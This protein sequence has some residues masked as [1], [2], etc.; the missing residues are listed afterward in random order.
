MCGF[1]AI[2]NLSG[3]NV[4][5]HVVQRMSRSIGHRGP[6][7]TGTYLKDSIGLG[8]R[9][10][11]ILDL[12]QA[13]NQ[14]MVSDCGRFVIVFNGEIFNYV[15]LR[16]ELRQLGHRFRSSGDTEVLLK[17]YQEWGSLCV[18]R[19]NGMWAFLIYDQV[20]GMLVGSRDRFG[21]KPLY[22]Y[23]TK[24]H[25]FYASEIKAI[26]DSGFYAGAT[27]WR[28]AADFL[29]RGKLDENENTMYEGVTQ[30]K[31]GSIFQIDM[32]GKSSQQTYWSVDRIPREIIQDP[33]STFAH[34]FADSIKLRMRS[35]VPVGV[36][37]S[38][39]L[40]STSIICE[41]AALRRRERQR[42]SNDDLL[43]FSFNT[44][45]FD[46]SRY[47]ADTIHQTN[48]ILKSLDTDPRRLWDSIEDVLWYHDEP[49]HAM[50]ALVGFNLM[51]LAASSGV[52][53]VL[54]GQGSDEVFAGYPSYFPSYWYSLLKSG[55]INQLAQQT[56][57]YAGNHKQSQHA[58]LLKAL[59][60][61]F[62][63]GMGGFP[64]YKGATRWLR[65]RKQRGNS[66]F[67][68][69]LTKYLI[70]ED[71]QPYDY[72]L[73]G[74][75]TSSVEQHPLP[76]YL[77]I[78]DRNSMAHSVE[79]RPPFLDHRLVE[80]GFNLSDNW[81][82]RGPWNKY[83]IRQAMRDR[84][85]DSVR[86]R[87][88]KMGFPTPGKQWFRTSLYECV[89]EIVV[90]RTTCERGI[91]N[92]KAIRSDLE[93]HRQGHI[94]VSGK[95]FDFAQFELLMRLKDSGRSGRE[96]IKQSAIA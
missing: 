80:F 91:Y 17:A 36:C 22:I 16:S 85:P 23:E 74:E 70:P 42:S 27:D 7:Q 4:A 72:T 94:D 71:R 73:S 8:F 58:L 95:L 60:K 62:S 78:E 75:L 21:I 51:S 19:F 55:R 30:I 84:I 5:E 56:A 25:V 40:D 93:S 11:S 33:P 6:D 37:L 96:V 89:S 43:A 44:L 90:S 83:I 67:S 47:I 31:P 2:L 86:T 50:P 14:P 63:A 18:N 3:G 48:A 92:I 20:K 54:N 76:L 61:T 9:R 79:A 46:E 28:T 35:D 12:S 34:L 88:D 66:W 53:V 15:E 26:R 68:P 29:L 39:G 52:K 13:G 1:V 24:D 64:P 69:E 82:L 38:G 65:Y 87:V 10:L 57:S 77:R 32:H 59:H 81:K 45:E 41:M 49:V